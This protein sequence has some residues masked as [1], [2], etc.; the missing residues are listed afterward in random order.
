[1]LCV[2]VWKH[3][4]GM[5]FKT[6]TRSRFYSM[7]E[8]LWFACC[9]CHV[10]PI[11]QFS[12]FYN[13]FARS[14]WSMLPSVQLPSLITP[15]SLSLLV[16]SQRLVGRFLHSLIV[17]QTFSLPIDWLLPGFNCIISCQ[18]CLHSRIPASWDVTW[19]GRP[20]HIVTVLHSGG[21]DN[22]WTH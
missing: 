21:S 15:N 14:L 17:L 10:R 6:I 20:Q 8:S 4:T 3:S 1:M 11:A 5:D 18:A 12:L 13:L 19:S 22:T 9:P 7:L 2:S 16:Q